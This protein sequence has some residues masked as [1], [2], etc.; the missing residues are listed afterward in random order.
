MH[1]I[2]EGKMLSGVK[3]DSI[4]IYWDQPSGVN[5]YVYCTPSI[6]VGKL[7][8]FIFRVTFVRRSLIFE[9]FVRVDLK[10]HQVF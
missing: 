7:F 3:T 1:E 9:T 5:S 2:E 10:S 4:R 8:V 6:Y